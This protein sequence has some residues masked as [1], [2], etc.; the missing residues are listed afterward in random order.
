MFRTEACPVC[1]ENISSFRNYCSTECGHKFHT[2]CLL[3]CNGSCLL[4]RRALI[5][6]ETE[7]QFEEIDVQETL[8]DIRA[9]SEYRESAK[10]AFEELDRF[11]NMEET[12]EHY[13]YK[14]SIEQMREAYKNKD[15][16]QVNKIIKEFDGQIDPEHPDRVVEWD[17]KYAFVRIK[18]E[19]ISSQMSLDDF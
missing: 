14:K 11:Y 18:R 4:C 17:L 9:K 8:F 10:F 12:E 6:D 1:L 2:N 15:L 19:L 7:S 13:G 3:R 5:P 16:N